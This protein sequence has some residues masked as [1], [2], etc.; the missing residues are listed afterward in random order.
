MDSGAKTSIMSV[1]DKDISNMASGCIV[2]GVEGKQ[3]VGKHINC[4]FS[5]DSMDGKVFEHPI[6]PAQIPG[7]PTLVIL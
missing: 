7:E 5:L 6:R 4:S 3:K 1:D 2:H